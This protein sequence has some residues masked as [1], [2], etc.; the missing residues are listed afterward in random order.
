MLSDLAPLSVSLGTLAALLAHEA[1]ISVQC[2]VPARLVRSL[3]LLLRLQLHRLLG[4]KRGRGLFLT[5]RLVQVVLNPQV[6]ALL[7]A[8]DVTSHEGTDHRREDVA[9]R[10]LRRPVALISTLLKLERHVLPDDL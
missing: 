3:L 10:V 5:L 9:C 6:K 4:S 1:P 8:E 7:I 2:V